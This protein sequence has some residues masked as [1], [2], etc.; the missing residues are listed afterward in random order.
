MLNASWLRMD[1]IY[2]RNWHKSHVTMWLE[3]LQ[4]W[5]FLS[6]SCLQRRG[7][8]TGAL[9]HETTDGWVFCTGHRISWSSGFLYPSVSALFHSR[10]NSSQKR[11]TAHSEVYSF[12]LELYVVWWINVQV[13]VLQGVRGKPLRCRKKNWQPYGHGVVFGGFWSQQQKLAIHSK[14]DCIALCWVL[15]SPFWATPMQNRIRDVFRVGQAPRSN[16]FV[17]NWALVLV[18]FSR[19]PPWICPNKWW[20]SFVMF[21]L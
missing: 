9:W 7:N 14:K 16:F 18:F 2:R 19:C 3:Q 8:W 20:V 6:V 13:V 12:L 21:K 15:P 17:P 5:Q 1:M 4:C 11:I 10:S